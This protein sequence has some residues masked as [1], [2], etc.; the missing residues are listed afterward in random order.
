MRTGESRLPWGRI[1]VSSCP[2]DLPLLPTCAPASAA[3]DRLGGGVRG[4]AGND[5][6][7]GAK[8]LRTVQCPPPGDGGGAARLSALFV[9]NARRILAGAGRGD[10]EHDR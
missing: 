8:R 9:S 1:R 3:A 2:R 6:R 7:R 10:V 5:R 4:A